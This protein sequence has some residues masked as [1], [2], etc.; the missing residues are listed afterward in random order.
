MRGYF[1]SVPLL[2]QKFSNPV[3]SIYLSSALA[4]TIVQLLIIYLLA[5]YITGKTNPLNEQFLLAGVLVTVLFQTFGYNKSIGII[6]PAVTYMFFYALALVYVLLFFLPFF[7]SFYHKQN[8]RFN[9]LLVFGLLF[10]SVILAFN[11]PLNPAVVLIV[12]PLIIVFKWHHYYSINNNGAFLKRLFS[13]FKAIPFYLKFILGFCLM[14]CV[15]SLFIGMNNASNILNNIPLWLRYARLP[16]GLYM[17]YLNETGSILLLALILVNAVL[18]KRQSENSERNKILNLLKWIGVF[19]MLYILL[20]PLGGYREYRPFIIRGDTIM[21]VTLCLFFFL[22]I[23]SVF[24][25]KSIEAELKNFYVMLLVVS[26]FIFANAESLNNRFNSCE[27]QSL[28]AISRSD[29]KIVQIEGN[30][31]I[32]AWNK[33]TDYH[34]SEIIGAMLLDWN[35]TKEKKLFY[36]K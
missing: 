21:P 7:L 34:D 28:E 25:I 20:L 36:Q 1:K 30:C 22:G 4:K 15:Y 8:I 12:C 6:D 5:I 18:I 24:L 14:L 2:F 35:I 23:S 19:S 31:S 27:R 10:L 9:F 29:E 32:I 3:D 16:E 26:G 33:I 11:G 17:Q 13:A